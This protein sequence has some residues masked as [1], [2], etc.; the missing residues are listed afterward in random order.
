MRVLPN[1]VKTVQLTNYVAQPY[2]I[3]LESEFL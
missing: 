2:I 1:I 3:G